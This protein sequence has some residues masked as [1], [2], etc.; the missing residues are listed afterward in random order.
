MLKNIYCDAAWREVKL[1]VINSPENNICCVVG[2]L[3]GEWLTEIF[4]ANSMAP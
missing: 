4:S 3:L 1:Y 2:G